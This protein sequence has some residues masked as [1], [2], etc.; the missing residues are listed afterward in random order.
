MNGTTGFNSRTNAT[1]RSALVAE[2]LNRLDQTWTPSPWDPSHRPVDELVGTILS[3]N[4]S[5]VNTARAFTSLKSA[6]PD[7][8]SVAI[9]DTSDVIESIRSGGLAQQKGPRIQQVLKQILQPDDPDPDTT[10]YETLAG[11]EPKSAMEWL[12]NF[13]GVGPKTAACVL[14]FAVG[15]PVVPVD[16]HVHRV[17]RRIGLIA[18]KASADQA[19][20]ELIDIV[21][22]EDSH[23]FHMHLIHHGRAIC[24]ARTPRCGE[25][26]LTDICD[27]FQ[28][29]EPDS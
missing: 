23:R 14:M 2:I 11:M 9:A 8:H 26:S 22:P 20:V 5:D 17:S 25:C 1:A 12:T 6:F 10:L 15:K 21:E 7:W 13:P 28:S 18:P 16:T 27:H 24:Q 4:T 3:Q 29:L 19:H